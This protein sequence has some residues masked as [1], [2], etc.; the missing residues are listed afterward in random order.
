MAAT[1]LV[2]SAGAWRGYDRGV[3]REEESN[4]L[5]LDQAAQLSDCRDYISKNT[6]SDDQQLTLKLSKLPAEAVEKCNFDN[7][8][9]ELFS[10]EWS[11]KLRA[12]KSLPNVGGFTV[13]KV[14]ADADIAFPS[15]NMLDTKIHE[16]EE[17]SKEIDYGPVAIEMGILSILS[18]VLTYAFGGLGA[19]FYAFKKE[20][21]S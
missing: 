16:L 17:N 4:R 19:A 12:E 6:D 1:F 11:V 9:V 21:Q 20:K 7:N 10:D 13:S 14:Y 2:A 3:Y 8:S 5:E 15:T 18:G